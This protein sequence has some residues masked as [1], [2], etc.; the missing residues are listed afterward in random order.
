MPTTAPLPA[1]V[2]TKIKARA[3]AVKW[4]AVLKEVRVF[5]AY[6][7]DINADGIMG[8]AKEPVIIANIAP[9]PVCLG[10][11][12]DWDLRDSY[13]PGSTINYWEIDFNEP[14]EPAI[15]GADIDDAVG[16][17]TYSSAG[18]YTIEIEIQEGTG[19]S[20]TME[21]E[22]NVVECGD[23]PITG[24]FWSYI[25]T[26]GEGVYYIDWTDTVPTWTAINTGLEG[27]ALNVRSLVLKPSSRQKSRSEHE[28]W[29]ATEDG[30][31]KTTDGGNSWGKVVM[32]DPSNVQFGDS[33]AATE[34]ELDW[35]HV[36]FDPTDENNVFILAGKPST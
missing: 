14:G 25:S 30:V 27:L 28:L 20:Q 16:T 26:E 23:G 18:T 12:I 34:G 5:A 24:E 11:W 32:G 7:C 3:Q 9:N 1:S 31:Y 2:T 19:R 22:V 17:F 21:I 29:A 15:T 8:V 35:Y 10:A 4:A 13:A 6:C 33:P 36:V